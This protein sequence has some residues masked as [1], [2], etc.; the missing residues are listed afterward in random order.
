MAQGKPFRLPRLFWVGF[1]IFVPGSA[2]LLGFVAADWL[3]LLSDPDPNPVGPGL[4]F[5]FTF[6]PSLAIM[7]AG[8]ALGL[9]RAR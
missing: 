4:L 3:G 2:P 7:A 8:V 9:W 5:F 1:W 6:W